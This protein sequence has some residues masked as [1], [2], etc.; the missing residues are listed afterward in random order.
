[1]ESSFSFPTTALLGI[2]AFA[3]IIYSFRLL[4]IRTKYDKSVDG[5]KKA[6][7]PEAG[8]AWR[9]IGHLHLLGGPVRPHIILASMAD[10]YGPIFTIK[11]GVHRAL[12]VSN[13]QIAKQCLTMND[14]TFASRPKLVSSE[15]MAYNYATFGLAPYGPYWRYVRKVA[16]LDLLSSHRL[17]LL[18]HVRDSEVQASMTHLYKRCMESYSGAPKKV[19]VDMKRWF[20]DITLNVVFRMIVGKRYEDKQDEKGREALRS[21]FDLTGKFIVSD[22]FPIL[23]WL[24][25]DG[26]ER[27]MKKTTQELDRVVQGWL[28]EHKSR[29]STNKRRGDN[30]D[31]DQDFMD[32]MLSTVDAAEELPGYDADTFIKATCLALILAGSHMTAV[33]LTWVLS[34]LLNHREVL[35]KAQHELDTQIGREKPVKESDL[36][37]LAYIQAIL[38]ETLRLYPPAP[39]GLPHESM[40]DCTVD[41]YHVPKGTRLLFN[42]WKIYRDPQVWLDPLE[43]RPERFLTTHKDFDIRGQNFELIPFGS[44]RRMCPG[45][46]FAMQMMSLSLAALLHGF[47]ITTPA[48]EPVDMAEAIRMTNLKATPLEV[49]ATPRVPEHVYQ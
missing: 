34:L 8:G 6:S 13:W 45:I 44:G 30:K 9:L 38:K 49:F 36:K 18:K 27:I 25:L 5:H 12:I 35:K 17:E 1:M 15:V 33:S 42:L 16:M 24:D 48:D 39:L 46:N 10:K 40:E 7:L 37:N 3:T 4:L 20:G 32:V 31:S 26:Y 21:Y 22:A 14:K 28:N 29:R 2:F 47:D 41:G 43:F 23:R 11:T 19:L